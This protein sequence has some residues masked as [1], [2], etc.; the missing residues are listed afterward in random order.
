M[1]GDGLARIGGGGFTPIS[2]QSEGDHE[3]I[4]VQGG[5]GGFLILQFCFISKKCVHCCRQY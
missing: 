4:G 3:E 1:P 2:G 5:G